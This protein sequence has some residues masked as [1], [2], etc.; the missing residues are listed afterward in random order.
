MGVDTVVPLR[1][2]AGW[3]L[4][5]NSLVLSWS[6]GQL[7]AVLTCW[8]LP[9]SVFVLEYYLDTLWKGMLLFVICLVFISCNILGQ[10]R[11]PAPHPTASLDR[12]T[13]E[14]LAGTHVH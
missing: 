13:Q 4:S 8:V 14:P 11:G 5:P 3:T 6:H 12:A 2:S 10:V 1:A 7:L 9:P